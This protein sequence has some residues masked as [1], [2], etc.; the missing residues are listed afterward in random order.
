VNCIIGVWQ[1]IQRKQGSD[2][3]VTPWAAGQAANSSDYEGLPGITTVLASEFNEGG[4]RI[5][6][7]DG[8]GVGIATGRIGKCARAAPDIQPVNPARDP[9]PGNELRRKAAA[10]SA[11][12]VLVR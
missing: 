4:R 3:A 10:P 1:E 7:Y 2:A 11:H 12:K 6:A 8:C 9:Q 5:A